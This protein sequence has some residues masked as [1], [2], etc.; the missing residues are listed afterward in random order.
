MNLH[1]RP[2]TVRRGVRESPPVLQAR[3]RGK[4]QP[5]EVA[6]GAGQ[7]TPLYSEAP[8]L[9]DVPPQG[10]DWLGPDAP[11]GAELDRELPDSPTAAGFGRTTAQSSSSRREPGIL[12]A[13]RDV[14][15][16]WMR[17]HPRPARGWLEQQADQPRGGEPQQE[18]V[19]RFD[20]RQRVASAR[21][22]GRPEGRLARTTP[23]PPRSPR[24][25]GAGAEESRRIPARDLSGLYRARTPRPSEQG[26]GPGRARAR[27]PIV[28]PG[29]HPRGIR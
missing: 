4:A 24:M 8:A 29:P 10:R 20:P 14:P 7:R 22:G 6:V 18:R 17:G 5:P 12:A 16:R 9:A 28:M 25:P 11:V 21:G 1:A 3:T 13:K 19:R 23:E 15:P 27:V 26:G 2:V